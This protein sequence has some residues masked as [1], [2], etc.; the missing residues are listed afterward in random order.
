MAGEGPSQG[1]SRNY[2]LIKNKKGGFNL[3]HAGFVYHK[4]TETLNNIVWTCVRKKT[5]IKCCGTIKLKIDID[6]AEIV[7][8][9]SPQCEPGLPTN[10]SNNFSEVVQKTCKDV[11]LDMGSIK[12]IYERNLKELKYEEGDIIPSYQDIKKKFFKARN[13]Y[14]GVPKTIFKSADD[15]VIPNKY[16]PV[17]LVDC[18]VNG[19]VLIFASTKIH[20]HVVGIQHYFCDGTFDCCSAPFSQLY[21]IHGDLGST[22]TSTNIVPL[23]YVLLTNKETAT[24][25]VMFK[26]IKEAVPAFNPAKFT[27]D[28][29]ASALRAIQ[30]VFPDAVIR[31]CFI[32]FQRSLFRKAQSLGLLAHETTTE[33]V[34]LCAS[35]ALLVKEDVEDGWLTIMEDSSTE[36]RVI[37]FND[38]FVTQWLED[39]DMIAKWCCHGERHR[40]TNLVEAWNQRLQQYVGSNPTLMFLLD[41]IELDIS[42]YDICQASFRQNQIPISHRKPKSFL[43]KDLIFVVR[44]AVDVGVVYRRSSPML[45]MDSPYLI[46]QTHHD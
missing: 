26:K 39:P 6:C 12:K 23:F 27:L 5:S 43:H 38:Y 25:E 35:L 46:C 18:K 16:K 4:H 40:T 8:K 17:L 11:C 45:N 13:E 30:N 19:R 1:R 29:E 20:Q 3:H 32:H 15:V 28:F 21:T 10:K 7:H 22:E 36:E 2:E 9:H 42:S 33:H 31:G 37:K 41:M 44:V 34:K 24:Y 14:L